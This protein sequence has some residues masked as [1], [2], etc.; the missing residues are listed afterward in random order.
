MKTCKSVTIALQMRSSVEILNYQVT[1]K[2]SQYGVHIYCD[3]DFHSLIEQSPKQGIHLLAIAL[4]KKYAEVRQRDLHISIDSI[5]VEIWGH[6]YFEMIFDKTK[7]L[8]SAPLFDRIRKRLEQATKAI[9]IA[10]R[11][12]DNNRWVWDI[13]ASCKKWIQR[14]LK[15]KY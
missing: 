10:E 9:D 7:W 3:N 6:H 12:H 2:L 4:K 14:F 5:V 13:L 15:D 11:G 1:F 8:I